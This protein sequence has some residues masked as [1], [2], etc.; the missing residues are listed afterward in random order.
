MSLGV[1]GRAQS[2]A[3]SKAIADTSLDNWG[4]AIFCLGAVSGTRTCKLFRSRFGDDFKVATPLHDPE[5]GRQDLPKS[6]LAVGEE[7]SQCFNLCGAYCSRDVN[8]TV[9][10]CS[11]L[12]HLTAVG[13]TTVAMKNAGIVTSKVGGSKGLFQEGLKSLKPSNNYASYH[14]L[15][16]SAGGTFDDSQL[17]VC[18]NKVSNRRV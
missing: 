12:L 9:S 5:R 1:S 7:R 14:S 16:V 18:K 11:Y 8:V 3:K 4:R 15:W 10:S 13:V 17:G 2:G 6:R